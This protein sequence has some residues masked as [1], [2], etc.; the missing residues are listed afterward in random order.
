[1]RE[2]LILL[3]ISCFSL[4]SCSWLDVE[5]EDQLTDPYAVTDASSARKALASAY[6]GLNIWQSYAPLTAMSDDVLPSTVLAKNKSLYNFY[7]WTGTELLNFANETWTD[8]YSV[9]ASANVVLERLPDVKVSSL[10]EQKE[11]ESVRNEAKAIKALCYFHLFRLF[12]PKYDKAYEND[13]KG[14]IAKANVVKEEPQRMTMKETADTIRNLLSFYESD[15]KTVSSKWLSPLAARCLL[16]DLELWTGNYEKAAELCMPVINS[17]DYGQFGE[18]GL[19]A[20]WKFSSDSP[21]T[22]FDIELPRYGYTT[23]DTWSVNNLDHLVVNSAVVFGDNDIRKGIYTEQARFP[24]NYA[25]STFRDVTLMGKYNNLR[26]NSIEIDRFNIYR[27][28]DFV[29]IYSE[30]CMRL[31]RKADA[32]SAMNS[33]LESC[34]ADTMSESDGIDRIILEKQKE[35]LCEGRRFY[36]LKRLSDKDL[37]RYVD[38]DRRVGKI[39]SDDYRWTMPIPASEYLYNKNITQNDGWDSL[40]SETEN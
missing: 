15:S 13:R 34:G 5:L 36:D 26:R 6:S 18:A 2:K 38:F 35:F 3:I 14:I 12:S 4:F 40:L 7:T 21:I 16:A 33:F 8:C 30:S 19:T 24:I 9:I 1:M 23:F 32:V 27:L 20:F 17:L 29:F 39:A 28:Q 11:I 22:V 37:D 31:G 10:A 25:T